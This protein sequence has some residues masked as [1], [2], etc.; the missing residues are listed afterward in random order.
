MVSSFWILLFSFDNYSPPAVVKVNRP[1]VNRKQKTRHI[2]RFPKHEIK[3]FTETT[4]LGKIL[5]SNMML[6]DKLM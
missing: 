5:Y 6:R 2:F 3:Y 1:N 4:N